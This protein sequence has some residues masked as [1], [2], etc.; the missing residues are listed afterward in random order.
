M[1]QAGNCGRNFLAWK[2]EVE[3]PKKAQSSVKGVG[4]FFSLPLS[5][6]RHTENK[7]RH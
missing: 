4:S 5:S 3:G 2:K 7:S 1:L 6:E